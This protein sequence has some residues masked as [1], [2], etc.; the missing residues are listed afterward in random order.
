MRADTVESAWRIVEPV[1]DH[2]SRDKAAFPNYASGEDG[3][4]AADALIERQGGRRWR[5]V[6]ADRKTDG[7]K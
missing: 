2:W 6:G 5:V 1:L 3:P 7:T 4:K